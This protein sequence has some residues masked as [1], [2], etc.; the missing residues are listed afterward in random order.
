MTVIKMEILG[1]YGTEKQYS[2]ICK[3]ELEDYDPPIPDNDA[4]LMPFMVETKPLE[5][6]MQN[7]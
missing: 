4:I 6:Q 3:M 1:N 7:R 2:K 5:N